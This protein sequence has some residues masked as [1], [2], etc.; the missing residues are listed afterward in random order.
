MP[1]LFFALLTGLLNRLL[2]GLLLPGAD[3]ISFR[4][5]LVIPVLFS[6]IV[7]PWVGGLIAMLG[8]F[9]GDYLLGYD[10]MFWHYSLANF[11]IGFIPGTVVWMGIKGIRKVNEFVTVLLFVFIG[12]AVPLFLGFA[13]QVMLYEGHTLLF[14][15]QTFYIPAV[16][17]NTYTLMLLVPPLLMLFKYIKMN[18]ETRT[19]F[20]F[21]FLSMVVLSVVAGVVFVSQQQGI[22]AIPKAAYTEEVAAIFQ[23]VVIGMFRWI[24][25]AL[26]LIVILSGGVGYFFSKKYLQPIN[27]LTEAATDLKMGAWQENKKIEIGTGDDEVRHLTELFNSMATAVVKREALMSREIERLKLSIDKKK[28]EKIVGEITETDFF[29]QLEERSLALKKKKNN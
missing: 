16:I 1:V 10:L 14:T 15:L 12:N 26:L 22:G 28:E 25:L 8:N 9:F 11:L 13:A 3:F 18:I 24:G 29:K 4:P 2:G 5:Q 17:S 21:F 27:K 19:M 6:L 23:G 20:V 7:S